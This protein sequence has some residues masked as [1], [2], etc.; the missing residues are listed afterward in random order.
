MMEI[1]TNRCW[2]LINPHRMTD[3]GASCLAPDDDVLAFHRVVPG[4]EPTPLHSLPALA[5]S[6]GVGELAADDGGAA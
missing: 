5:K 3:D 6:I 4:Y 2:A 1:V